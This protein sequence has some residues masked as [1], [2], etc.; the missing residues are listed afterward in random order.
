MKFDYFVFKY[1]PF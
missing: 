1:P